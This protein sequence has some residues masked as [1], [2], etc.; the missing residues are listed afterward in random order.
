MALS[1]EVDQTQSHCN[2]ESE[3]GSKSQNYVDIF[4]FF[5]YLSEEVK[6]K[7][8]SKQG[9]IFLTMRVYFRGGIFN[10]LTIINWSKGFLQ[11]R[12][13]YKMLRISRI[14]AKM[15]KHWILDGNSFFR[16]VLFTE[17]RE[18]PLNFFPFSSNVKLF[19]LLLAWG[20]FPNR[21]K[22]WIWD[23][24]LADAEPGTYVKE[25]I[26]TV[27]EC[28]PSSQSHFFWCYS[29]GLKLGIFQKFFIC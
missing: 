19:W 26:S 23:T 22:E 25:W 17:R 28:Y 13:A 16:P 2:C 15:R 11:N 12:C 18:G 5:E 27:Q 7:N 20:H 1:P 10:R 29:Q 24:M 14:W 6:I 4:E 3:E 21:E 9:L 8:I